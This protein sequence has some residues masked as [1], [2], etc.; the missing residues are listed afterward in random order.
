[1]EGT[2]SEYAKIEK[3]LEKNFLEKGNEKIYRDMVN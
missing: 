2:F 3:Y 1:M